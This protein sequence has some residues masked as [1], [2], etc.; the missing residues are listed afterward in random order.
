MS[1]FTPNSEDTNL[2]PSIT[3]KVSGDIAT[4]SS[5]SEFGSESNTNERVS[6]NYEEQ[7]S[8]Y[9]QCVSNAPFTQHY[10]EQT[11]IALDLHQG[12]RIFDLG[13]GRGVDLQEI[14]EVVAPNGEVYGLD[15]AVDMVSE[16]NSLHQGIGNII[17]RLADGE[18]LPF[19]DNYFDAGRSIRV[20]Q[21]VKNLESVLAEMQR[22]TKTGGKIVV[23]DPDWES[24]SIS[25]VASLKILSGISE[26]VLEA[27]R[28]TIQNPNIP[29]E[30]PE[31]CRGKGLEVLSLT[32]FSRKVHSFSDANK[33]YSLGKCG[34]FLVDKGQLSEHHYQQWI[35]ACE[36]A[37][38]RG[39]FLLTL[40][41]VMITMEVA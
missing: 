41:L 30:V 28:E 31:L 10:M 34:R 36:E 8:A 11:R 18:Q 21:H 39:T 6:S 26:Q 37:T 23:L 4:E 25:P 35:Q 29:K 24:L 3:P 33:F 5:N 22:V 15:N 32:T 9:L 12:D 14:A 17:I 38:N 1:E 27:G 2:N 19:D 20:L 7:A 16:A 13:C 40:T